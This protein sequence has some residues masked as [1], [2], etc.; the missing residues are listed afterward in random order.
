[1]VAGLGLHAVRLKPELVIQDSILVSHPSPPPKQ[2][3]AKQEK[4]KAVQIKAERL[5]A[6]PR[7]SSSSK[8]ELLSHPRT[9]LAFRDGCRQ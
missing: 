7:S 5:H 9:R 2:I 6:L 3:I 4:L 8:P 1:M